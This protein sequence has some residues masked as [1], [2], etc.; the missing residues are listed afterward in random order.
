MVYFSQI[1]SFN[2]YNLSKTHF[3][4]DSYT[5]ISQ[6]VDIAMV[7]TGKTLQCISAQILQFQNTLSFSLAGS[8]LVLN[9]VAKCGNSFV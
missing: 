8:F 1:R 3:W 4:R 2:R 5:V 6:W 7:A 9:C